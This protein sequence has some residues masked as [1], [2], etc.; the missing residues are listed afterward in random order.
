MAYEAL[1]ADV[2]AEIDDR[3]GCFAYQ[4][5]NTDIQEADAVSDIR[6]RTP[7]ALH[8]LV[9]RH[10]VTGTRSLYFDP[11]QTFAIEG[12]SAERSDELV[13]FLSEHL[14][15]PAWM[16]E[17]IWRMGDVMMWDNARLL[18]SRREFD[19]RYPRLA[20]RT[21]IFLRDDL[22]PLPAADAA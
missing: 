4:M 17:H 14:V 3:R 12:L 9:L 11:T 16:Q 20:K 21:T 7:D 18:H 22:F 10:P 6:G 8:P 15:N 1:P 5:Y 13:A 19:M 2:K